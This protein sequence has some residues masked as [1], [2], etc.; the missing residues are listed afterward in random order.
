[1]TK[2]IIGTALMTACGIGLTCNPCKEIVLVLCIGAALGFAAV[3]SGV[4][5]LMEQD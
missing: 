5:T 3:C 2:I 1:M 4:K